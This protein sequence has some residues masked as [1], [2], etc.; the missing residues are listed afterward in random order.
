MANI[1]HF[2]KQALPADLKF[3]TK[4][5]YYLITAIL[6]VASIPLGYAVSNAALGLFVAATLFG[7]RKQ[8]FRV[9][10]VLLLPVLLFALMCLSTLWSI[11]LPQTVKA[12]SKNLPML[13]IPLCFMVRPVTR[14][15]V[16]TLLKYYSMAMVA[17]A[18]WYL[19][20]AIVRYWLSGN[21]SVF[22]YHE[23]T[24]N[25]VNAIHVSL[26][27]G[28]A[29]FYYIN[30][31]GKKIMHYLAIAIFAVMILLLSSK[32]LIITTF[33]MVGVYFLFFSEYKAKLKITF[34]ASI[35]GMTVAVIVFVPKIRERFVIE[36][37]TFFTKN[38][39]NHS[40][41]NDQAKVYN[42]SVDEALNQQSF[43]YNDYFPGIALRVFLTRIF[44]EMAAEDD[45]WI[46][47][48]GLNAAQDKIRE[49]VES[50]NLYPG[51]GE[52][53]FHNQYIQNFAEL[54]VFGLLIFL[55]IIVINAK[56]S[57]SRKDFVHISLAFLLI[58]LFLTESL[59]SRQRGILFFMVFYCVFN[60]VKAREYQEIKEV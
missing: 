53:N 31:S 10:T 3:N 33:A 7:F 43:N 46:T 21:S 19:V 23:L 41:G 40:I 22:F 38:T 39:V 11:N 9:S 59:L 35:I 29:F 51:Y 36:T 17:Y 50:Y 60:A 42:I 20:R 47:G 13:L 18:L 25:D 30:R 12:L 57:F 26:Y 37:S 27:M 1:L 4:P 34:I 49:K 24:T 54:G 52:F 15:Q 14:S 32:S 16:N 6:L 28:L 45:I 2:L 5:D 58:T 56:N 8:N 44:T 48:Y 55:A